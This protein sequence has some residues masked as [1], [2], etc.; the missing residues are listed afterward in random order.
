MEEF[1]KNIFNIYDLINNENEKSI[2]LINTK[3]ISKQYLSYYIYRIITKYII[4]VEIS[5]S[6]EDVN[7]FMSLLRIPTEHNRELNYPMA[8]KM[9]N[10]TEETNFFFLHSE[11]H[12]NLINKFSN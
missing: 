5:T 3:I 10:E 4:L 6:S 1:K 12:F 2:S 11:K 7:F 8:G 9:T